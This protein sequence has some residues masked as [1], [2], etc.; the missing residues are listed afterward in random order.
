M[1]LV[2]DDFKMRGGRA[3]YLNTEAGS[4]QEA[5]YKSLGYRSLPNAPGSMVQVFQNKQLQGSGSLTPETFSW[6]DWPHL[7]VLL[8]SKVGATVRWNAIGLDALGSVESLVLQLFFQHDVLKLEGVPEIIVLRNNK[9]LLSGFFSFVKRCNDT[10]TQFD[11]YYLPDD[12]IE[13]RQIA[14]KSLEEKKVD[15]CW[16]IAT[17][18]IDLLKPQELGFYPAS[19]SGSS[20]S[21]DPKIALYRLGLA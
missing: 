7:N 8:L 11:F 13:A 5:F 18:D 6:G 1:D 3:L 14:S 12:A 21:T 9:G 17:E 2:N 19:S 15:L 16:T 10:H 20:P 4:Y